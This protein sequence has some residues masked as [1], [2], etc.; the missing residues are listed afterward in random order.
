M[1]FDPVKYVEDAVTLRGHRHR[2]GAAGLRGAAAGARASPTPT[3]PACAASPAAPRPLPV[4]ADR[5]AEGAAA[6]RGHRRGLRAHRGDHAG[7]RQPVVPVRHP[8]ARHRRR[9]GVRHRDHHPAARRRRPAARRRARRGLHPR[10]AGD[11]RLRPPARR[12]PPSRSTP[13]AG[14]TPAT[15]ASSTRTATC[16]SS[17]APRTCCSTRATTCSR[18]SSRRSCSACPGWPAP[19]WSGRPDEEAGELP[20]AYVVRK[21]DDAGAALTAESVM[22]AVNDKVTPYKRL[23]DVVFIDAIPVSAAGKVLKRELAA[24]EREKVDGRRSLTRRVRRRARRGRAHYRPRGGARARRRGDRAHRRPA[25]PRGAVAGPPG[26]APGACIAVVLL[27]VTVAVIYLDRD[28]YRDGDDRRPVA[29][30]TPSTT[31]RSPSR[32]PA[33]AT[34]RRSPRA[35]GWSTSC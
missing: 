10:P 18:A 1:R 20:V 25:R 6:Q 12:P 16:R 14:S 17:T 7:H 15:S 21:A 19:R 35:R 11:A 2:R 30:S 32:P 5:E 33:T 9:A 28:G 3:G 24:K 4:A 29:C 23:R 31:R 27:A 8:Q 34:S 22:A 26:V 13:T